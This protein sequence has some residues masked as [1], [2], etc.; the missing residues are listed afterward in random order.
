MNWMRNLAVLVASTLA[1]AACA[2][3]SADDSPRT[4]TGT[5]PDVAYDGPEAGLPETYG[6]ATPVTSDDCVIGYLDLTAAQQSL[7]A[8]ELGAVARAEELGCDI[9]VLDDELNPTKQVN[10]F[11][12]LLA[13]EVSAIILYP[14]VPD[15]MQP[16]IDKAADA[17]IPVIAIQTPVAADDETPKGYATSVLQ[18]FDKAAYQRAK[19]VAN[20]RPGSSYVIQGLAAPVAALQYFAERQ[21]YWADKF[22][23]EFLGQDDV[24]ADSAAAAATSMTS[25]IAKYPDVDAVFSFNDDSVAAGATILKGAGKTDVLLCGFNGQLSAFEAIKNGGIF[26]TYQPDY[27]TVGALTVDAAIQLIA[28]ADAELPRITVAPGTLITAENV[29]SATPLGT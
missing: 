4:G 18:G 15:A 24:Q 16:S 12:Q 27:T 23:L 29:E 21:K 20:E 26:A 6:D 13:R 5:A 7:K 14:M 1:L 22:G 10:N 17:G 9:V 8:E 2:D 19:A 28:D 11:D 25:I 3:S